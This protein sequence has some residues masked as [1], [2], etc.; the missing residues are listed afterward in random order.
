[1]ISPVVTKVRSFPARGLKLGDVVPDFTADTTEGPIDLHR[2][3]GPDGWA[4]FFSHP[5]DYTPVCS[6]EMAHAMEHVQEVRDTLLVP[7]FVQE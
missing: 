1:M 7:S 6:T 4:I 2:W 3:L 5:A